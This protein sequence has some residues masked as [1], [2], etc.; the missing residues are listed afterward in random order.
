MMAENEYS[1]FSQKVRTLGAAIYDTLSDSDFRMIQWYILNNCEEIEKYLN[2]HMEE[3]QKQ[4]NVDLQQR[5]QAEFPSWLKRHVIKLNLE[6]SLESNN[7][8]YVLGLGPDTLITRYTGIIVNGIRFH[9]IERGTSRRTQNNGVLVKGV[10]NSEEIDFYG[11]LI[12]IIELDYCNGNKVFIF[13]CDWWNVGDKKNGLRTNGD[14]ISVN[15]SRKW[16]T[17][18][19]FVLATQAKQVFYIDDVKNGDNWKIVQK[20]NHRHIFNVPEVEGNESDLASNDD[21]YQQF[22]PV[23]N[24]V[25]QINIESN[26]S[27]N[28]ETEVEEIDSS[29]LSLKSRSMSNERTIHTDLFDGDDED[30]YDDDTILNY[31]D[32]DG[33]NED[34]DEEKDNDD[35]DEL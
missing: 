4:G 33:E 22:E 28:Q 26:E 32:G 7:H 12:D 34:I 14:L 8:L 19:P 6:G 24:D 5:H 9:S 3:V 10:H 21:P 29:F 20:T 1:I 18:D 13:K 31:L 2:M 11:Q 15:V 17:C 27:L 35:D 23:S 25:H 16:Y 30:D